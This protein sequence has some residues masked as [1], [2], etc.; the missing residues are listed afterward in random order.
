MPTA[1]QYSGYIQ[2]P[3]GMYYSPQEFYGP[4]GISQ[5]AGQMGVTGLQG[6]QQM[7]L[8]GLVGQQQSSLAAQLAQQQQSVEE[9]RW[10]RAMEFI[11]SLG[12]MPQ[13]TGGA[14]GGQYGGQVAS[15]RAQ[16][17][18]RSYEQAKRGI[19]QNIAGRGMGLSSASENAQGQAYGEL[20]RG[21]AEA[22]TYGDVAQ[23]NLQ[24]SLLGQLL[25]MGG[26]GGRY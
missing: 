4:G 1:G 5:T 26:G 3:S 9:A 11:Q 12:I 25:Q 19:S 10:R 17:A 7:G 16:P 8:Q 6:Q 2:D 13:L 21:L 20:A 24:Y 18:I 14:M 15:Q 23:Q 22:G